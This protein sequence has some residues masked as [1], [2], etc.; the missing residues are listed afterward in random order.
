M[1][2][3]TDDTITKLAIVA[4]FVQM[5]AEIDFSIMQGLDAELVLKDGR[6]FVMSVEQKEA[7]E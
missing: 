7:G 5:L 2:Q 3:Q 4:S 1:T 6:T